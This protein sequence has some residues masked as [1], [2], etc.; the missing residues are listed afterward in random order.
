M[1]VL[2][3]VVQREGE[4]AIA[5]YSFTDIVNGAGYVRYYGGF[6]DTGDYIMSPTIFHSNAI[7]TR[8]S[9]SPP[10]SKGSAQFDI[11]FD[12]TEFTNPRN[13]RGTAYVSVP[14]AVNVTGG[15]T[16]N[17][18]VQIT[19]RVRKWDG[20]TE[21]DI[22]SGD[23]EVMQETTNSTGNI[24]GVATAKVAVSKTLF[25][26]GETLRITVEFYYWS[27]QTYARS[28]SVAHSPKGA[29]SDN[30]RTSLFSDGD[31]TTMEAL[32]PYEIEL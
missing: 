31:V 30:F 24:Q 15:A 13:I 4:G 12:T 27:S 16:E 26:I 19:A 22:A 6:I 21:T 2:P 17:H 11:D 20:S 28:A 10:T 25:K 1:V 9:F 32:V 5:S 7:E 14:F 8:D 3:S 29:I 23:S 18:N